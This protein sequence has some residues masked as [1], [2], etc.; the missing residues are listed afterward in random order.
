MK[1]WLT[2]SICA[3]LGTLGTT[4][5]Y[6]HAEC[7]T[8]GGGSAAVSCTS[9]EGGCSSGLCG[10]AG[11]CSE[12]CGCSGGGI[13]NRCQGECSDCGASN[14]DR[15]FGRGNGCGSGGKLLSG[16]TGAA[17][18]IGLVGC[19]SCGCGGDGCGNVVHCGMEAPQY[20]TPFPTPRPTTWTELTYPPMAPHNSLPHYRSTYSFRHGPGLSRTTVAWYPTKAWNA[21]DRLHNV[22]EIAR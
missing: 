16:L 14:A 11:G 15:M 4:A 8:C 6:V 7:P 13:F 21:L 22:F 12:S 2:R 3:F 18:R 19:S 20:P 5:A 9:S 17:S 1:L 10:G